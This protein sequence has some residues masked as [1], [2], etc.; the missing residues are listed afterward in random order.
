MDAA[1]SI[2][3]GVWQ[4]FRRAWRTRIRSTANY[5]NVASRDQHR[6]FLGDVDVFARVGLV[7]GRKRGYQ[8]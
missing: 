1:V 7:A 6:A 3:K 4:N 5:E 8:Y 2:R